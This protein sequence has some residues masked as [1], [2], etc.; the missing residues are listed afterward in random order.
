MPGH[1]KT[2]FSAKQKKKQLQEK[3]ER[4]KERSE[5]V[6]EDGNV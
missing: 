1:R 6:D 3:R 4:K 2:P 5:L